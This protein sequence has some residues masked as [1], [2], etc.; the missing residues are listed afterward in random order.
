[1]KAVLC[2]SCG[3]K[4]RRN[5]TTGAGTQRRGCVACGA[6]ATVP[7]G[8]A[9]SRPE[10]L[11]PRL[12]SED[13]QISM[14]G[15]GRTF[16][17]RTAGLWRVWPMPE[18][19]GGARRV[20]FVDGIWLDRDLVA[21]M[22]HD[23]RHAISWYLARAETSRAWESLMSPMPAPDVVGGAPGSPGRGGGRGRARGRGGASSTPSAR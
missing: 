18:Q 22:A 4:T 16:R 19:T 15:Q 7:C 6:S 21:P 12:M 14:P 9:A 23:G 17:R 5:G 1:M 3:A 10:E 2:P 8:D 13:T 20:V 11:L